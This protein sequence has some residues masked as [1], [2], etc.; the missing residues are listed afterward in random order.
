M[1]KKKDEGTETEV[2]EAA[3]VETEAQPADGK[4]TGEP[5]YSREDIAA[6]KK[7]RDH[8]WIVY[9]VIAKGE[10]VTLKEAERRINNYLNRKI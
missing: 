8:K 9:A 6:S 5:T 10:M 4:T 2:M 3:V 7:F 1:G